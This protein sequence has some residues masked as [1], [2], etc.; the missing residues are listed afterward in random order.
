[1]Y[2]FPIATVR[3]D[4]K[5]SDLNTTNSLAYNSGGQKSEIKFMGLK[6]RC[7]QGGI[8]PRGSGGTCFLSSGCLHSL[9][10]GPITLTS[11]SVATLLF[12]TLALLLPSY[13]DP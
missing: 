9:A 3:N 1:M 5:P 11:A 7:G 13:K 2:L 8:S 4:H 6:P 10:C 12:L